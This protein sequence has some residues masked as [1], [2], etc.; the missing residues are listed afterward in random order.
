VLGAAIDGK[1]GALIGAL[2]GGT[3]TVVATS[4]D[5]V[6]LPAGTVLTLRLERPLAVAQR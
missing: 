5:E 4:G 1:S 2:V 6:E 3:G